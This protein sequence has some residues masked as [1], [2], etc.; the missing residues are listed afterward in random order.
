MGNSCSDRGSTRAT[1]NSE[2][3]PKQFHDGMKA[4]NTTDAQAQVRRDVHFATFTETTPRRW[5]NG[6]HATPVGVATPTSRPPTTSSTKIQ[7][8]SNAISSA[9]AACM[10]RLRAINANYQRQPTSPNQVDGV[11]GSPVFPLIE[12]GYLNT[13]IVSTWRRTGT[14]MWYICKTT[15]LAFLFPLICF[16][17][18]QIRSE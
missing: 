11:P 5:E 13:W 6:Q 1:Y 2:F 15:H 3:P 9:E 14:S 8:P 10:R 4:L 17:R 12:N 16:T 7:R 18:R